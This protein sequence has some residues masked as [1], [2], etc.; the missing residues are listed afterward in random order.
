MEDLQP[1]GGAVDEVDDVVEP[2]GQEVDVLAVE[3]SDEHAVEPGHHVMGDLVSLVL[4]SLDLVDDG[5][6][7]VAV[8]REE[9]PLQPGSL[10]GVRGDGGEQL[11]E[12][13]IARQE[14]HCNVRVTGGKKI[15]R[16]LTGAQRGRAS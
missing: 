1:A 4:E 13:L 5:A 2:G 6:S 14:S 16:P 9:L 7:P 3:R 10:H 8:G 11:E 15:T 12:F